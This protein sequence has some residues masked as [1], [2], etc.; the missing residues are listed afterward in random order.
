MHVLCSS[1][2]LSHDRTDSGWH[3]SIEQGT[4]DFNSLAVQLL[5]NDTSL[6][7]NSHQRCLD[8][9]ARLAREQSKL[10]NDLKLFAS[11]KVAYSIIGENQ[12]P[13]TRALI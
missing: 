1:F 7:Y 2:S 11:N 9:L 4:P 3:P 5:V 6:L 10:N 12:L 8:Q 13:L